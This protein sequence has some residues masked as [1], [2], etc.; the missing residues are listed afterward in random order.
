MVID[1]DK[2]LTMILWMLRK[3]NH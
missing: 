3:D 1:T 2:V